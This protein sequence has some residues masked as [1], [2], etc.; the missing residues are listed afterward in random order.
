MRY[1]P[2]QAEYKYKYNINGMLRYISYPDETLNTAGS[3]PFGE[4]NPFKEYLYD[5]PN[6]PQ[7]LTSIIDTNGD[8]FATWAYD[9]KGRAI[10]S[11]HS[12][13]TEKVVIDYTHI[14]D[15]SDP[16]VM[17]ANVLGKQTTYHYATPLD[18]RKVTLVEGHP[19]ANC[20]A[21]NKN[22]SY[23]AN[24]FLA[25]KT[26]WKGNATTYIRN[27]KGQDLSRTE[28]AGTPDERIIITEWHAT[29][30]LRTKVAEPDR[31]TVYTY[32]T[33]GNLLSQQRTDLTT[34]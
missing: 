17:T 11:E 26:D 4:D 22:Y 16:R 20:L 23:D 15:E 18:V 32:D 9:S 21:A 14:N 6:F 19:S 30:N 12:G 34:P 1:E 3:N 31:E 7:A 29:F 8:R 2:S 25:S 27:A 28:A 5:D 33:N 24:G 10:S 13:G